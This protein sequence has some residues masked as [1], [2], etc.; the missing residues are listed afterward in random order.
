MIDIF[1]IFRKLSDDN[2]PNFKAYT[3][4]TNLNGAEIDSGQREGWG[5]ISLAVDNDTVREICED[6][7]TTYILLVYKIR[8]VLEA[9]KALVEKGGNNG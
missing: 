8:D 1:D 2:N 7:N 4:H 6:D 5:S 3:G 9:Q